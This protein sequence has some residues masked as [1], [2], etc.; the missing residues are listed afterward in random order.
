MKKLLEKKAFTLIEVVLAIAI[1]AAIALP[2]FNVF[3][4]SVKTDRI[5]ND[6]LNANYIS[7]DY[8]EKLDA[9]IY[10]QA[11]NDCPDRVSVENY[12]LTASIRPYGTFNSMFVGQCSYAHLVMYEEGGMLAVMPDGKW[13]AFESVPENITLSVSSGTYSFTG[14]YTTIT[15]ISSYNYCAMLID[16][17][18][19]PSE[20]TTTITLGSSCKAVVYCQKNHF[21]DFVINGDSQ[22][23]EDIMA[24]T[25]SLVYV[26]AFV[27]NTADS[28]TAVAVSEGYINIKNW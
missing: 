27:Y 20:T 28:T 15:G 13:H 25:T 6:V 3:V 14:D 17:M 19:K 21:N 1:F 2:L 22:V 23:Y 26:G 24:G 10:Q 8:I 12:Y 16:G 5:S 11:L 18:L 4:Q 9:T 7:Q